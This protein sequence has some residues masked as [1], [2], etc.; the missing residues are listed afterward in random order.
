MSDPSPERRPWPPII[1]A[2]LAMPLWA[3]GVVLPA[4]LWKL[5]TDAP[6][7]AFPYAIMLGGLIVAT[8]VLLRVD[9]RIGPQIP[10]RWLPPVTWFPLAAAVAGM[11][12]AIVVSELH[13]VFASIAG[14]PLDPRTP[15]KG[16]P[17]IVAALSVAQ[18]ICLVIVL[19]GVVQRAFLS[20][21]P[22]RIAAIG[23]LVAAAFFGFDVAMRAVPML[24]LPTWLYVETRSLASPMAALL[25]AGIAT[26]L[27][28]MG[29]K[30]GVAGFDHIAADAQWQPMWFNALGLALLIGGLL[31]LFH[32][33][34]QP[35]D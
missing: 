12:A 20:A 15:P 33:F 4:V 28:A 19:Q 23:T 21:L 25:P 17:L 11:G 1:W 31:P 3:T 18:P 32:A 26:S 14:T 5:K 6:P 7:D 2:L 9:A 35:E 29:M 24:L 22:A 16:D 10:R 27:E 34:S 13:N 30:M 8:A